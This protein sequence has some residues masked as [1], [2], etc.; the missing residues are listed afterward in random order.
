MSLMCQQNSYLKELNTHVKSCKAASS[1]VSNDG[2]LIKIQCFEVILEDTILFPEGGG[3][4][5]DRGTINDIPVLRV[6]RV[7][8]N[9]VHFIQSEIQE[10]AK[11]FVKLDWPRR[12]DHMQQHT[13]QHLIT[14]IIDQTFGYQTTSWSLGTDI[15]SIELN[16]HSLS[17]DQMV[18]I[19][20][21]VNE[22]IRNNI[23]VL[24]TLYKDKDD[25]ELTKSRCLGL[26]NDHVGPVRMVA[27]EGIDNALCCGTHAS[28]LTHVQAIKLLETEKGKKNKVNLKFIAGQR[29]LQFVGQS[30]QRERTLTAILK[31][32]QDKQCELADKAIRGWKAL[33]KTCNLQLREIATLEATLF[34]Q[35]A[36]KETIF[37]HHRKDGDND[38]MSVLVAALGN[39]NLPKLITV[40]D[41]KEGGMFVFAGPDHLVQDLGKQICDVFEGKGAPSKSMFRGKTSKLANR[42]KAEKLIREYL[43]LE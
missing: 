16:T 18:E 20:T 2:K 26:P 6:L 39:E 13:A 4:P 8:E 43:K 14:A 9:A 5:D 11:V 40:G 28:N 42:K 29:L 31:G 32:P 24:T 15:V 10:N 27:I 38:Y 17:S 37:I 34:K 7:G 41:D 30:Y 35:S 12:F 25:P 36:H 22:C 33:Q 1:Y 21:K 23:A 19:E 3:Q